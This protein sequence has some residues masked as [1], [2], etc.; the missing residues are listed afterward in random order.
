M[1]ASILGMYNTWEPVG[2]DRERHRERMRGHERVQ[3]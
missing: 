1:G 3:E 2:S